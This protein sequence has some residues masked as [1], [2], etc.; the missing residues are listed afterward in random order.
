MS[1]ELE[2]VTYTREIA[3]LVNDTQL[4]SDEDSKFLTENVQHFKD[5]M[6]NTYMW[7]TMGQKLS[8]I[9]DQ[10]HPTIHGKFHQAILEAKVQFGE[11]FRLAVDAEKAKLDVEDI[12]L[13]IEEIEERMKDLDETS[14]QYRKEDVLLRRKEIEL[15]EK[16][17]NLNNFKT[18]AFYRMRELKQWK[19]IQDVL[20]ARMEE[21][22]MS[23]DEIWN[24]EASELEDQFFQ[25]INKLIGIPQST[26]AGEV[27][28]LVGLAR[29]AVEQ[30]KQIGIFDKL[31]T[32]CNEQQVEILRKFGFM[33]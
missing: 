27:N 23:E 7:R 29:Y 19:E 17:I 33:K 9:S 22:G 25:F 32:K 4:L 5:I 14:V 24:K 26:N 1:N 18:A 6:E 20:R 15:K 30:A 16:A 13:D 2:K 11:T 10:F 8:I 3:K 21:A 28:N 12:Q 31:I